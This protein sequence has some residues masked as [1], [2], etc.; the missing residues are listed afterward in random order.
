[1]SAFDIGITI[2]LFVIAVELS[3]IRG[4]LKNIA[5]KEKK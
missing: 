3:C 5:N 2:L 4:Y 1:M